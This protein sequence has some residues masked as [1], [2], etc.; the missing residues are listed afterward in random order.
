MA[1][2]D[3]DMEGLAA[4]LHLPLTKVARMAERGKLPGRRVGGEWRFS[5]SEIHHWMEERIGASD[6][7]ELL[8]LEGALN[9]AA[10]PADYTISIESL[11]PL[12]T[13]CTDLQART[14]SSV[15]RSMVDLAAQTGWLWDPD[16]MATALREREEMY[17]TAMDNGMA[18]LHPRRPMAKILARP[19]LAIGRTHTGIPFGDPSGGLTDL[20]FLVCSVDDSGHLRTLARLGRLLGEADVVAKLRS[21]D[22]AQPLRDFLIEF[23][24]QLRE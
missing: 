17:P 1:S 3:F 19:F 9:R 13:V 8:H 18:L 21:I 10:P 5:R 4:Y 14:K 11:M 22:E 7:D 23:E 6:E 15:I 2:G 24:Q 12:E 16:V 20:F